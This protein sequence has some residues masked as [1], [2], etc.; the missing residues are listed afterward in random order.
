MPLELLAARPP[1]GHNGT[2]VDRRRIRADLPVKARKRAVRLPAI[3]PGLKP[4]LHTV[5][6]YLIA[7]PVVAQ[8]YQYRIAQ[9]L[10]RNTGAGGAK[11]QGRA[12]SA[13]KPQYLHDLFFALH[14]D[15]EFRDQL[16]EA[17]ICTIGE[18]AQWIVNHAARWDGVG[19]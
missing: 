8:H 6:A 12:L 1:P 5:V 13:R 14:F 3:H 7:A 18:C 4:D 15:N 16:I 9:C 10:T 2:D 17:C 11:R 19:E